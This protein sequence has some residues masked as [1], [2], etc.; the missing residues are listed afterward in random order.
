M[1]DRPICRLLAAVALLTT[2]AHPHFAVAQV[3]AREGRVSVFLALDGGVQNIIG[4]ALVSGVDVLS[5]AR[6]TVGTVS[7]GV[8]AESSFGL[9]AGFDVGVGVARGNLRLVDPDGPLEVSYKNRTQRHWNVM[10]GQAL[11]PARETTIHLYLSEVSRSFEVDVNEAGARYHQRDGQGLLRFGVG[12]ERE[13][14]SATA[15]R[16]RVGTSRADFGG[17]RTNI[18]PS[19]LVDVMVGMAIRP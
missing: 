7:L 5:Q 4:G 14:T 10:V 6:R 15:L 2:L 9:V 17:R 13:V 16:L 11:G 12:I 1:P 8:R 18:T 3:P 19:R